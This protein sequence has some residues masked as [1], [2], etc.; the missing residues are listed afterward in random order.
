MWCV[1]VDPNTDDTYM[2]MASNEFYSDSYIVGLDATAWA[3]ENIQALA[4][5]T[6]GSIHYLYGLDYT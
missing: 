3:T 6:Y 1:Q 2:L 4:K 5:A